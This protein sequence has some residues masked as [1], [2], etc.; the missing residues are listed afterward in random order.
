VHTSE[1]M[2]FFEKIERGNYPGITCKKKFC[3]IILKFK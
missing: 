1:R 3:E 2:G